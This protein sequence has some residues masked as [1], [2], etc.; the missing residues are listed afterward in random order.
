MSRWSS[1]QSIIFTKTVLT[2]NIYTQLSGPGISSAIRCSL[3]LNVIL[4]SVIGC[5]LDT[6]FLGD[7]TCKKVNYRLSKLNPV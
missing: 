4:G 1:S 2:Y 3:L 6:P 5:L 7:N